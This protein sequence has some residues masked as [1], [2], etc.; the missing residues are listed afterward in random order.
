MAQIIKAYTLYF[1]S[2]NNSC[3]THFSVDGTSKKK[4]LKLGKEMVK[5]LTDYYKSNLWDI[6][7]TVSVEEY[8][9]PFK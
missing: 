9:S 5:A 1:H 8:K 6:H 2:H 7:I 3:L 4:A